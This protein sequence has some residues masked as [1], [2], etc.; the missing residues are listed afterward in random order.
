LFFRWN[1]PRLR[2][3]TL[4]RSREAVLL[5]DRAEDFLPKDMFSRVNSHAA[6]SAL[7][8]ERMLDEPDEAVR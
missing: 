8:P 4:S 3:W 7:C 5:E 1:S 2:N 6:R